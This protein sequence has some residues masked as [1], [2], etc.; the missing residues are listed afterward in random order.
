MLTALAATIREVSRM[1][2]SPASDS[3][4]GELF[5][6]SDPFHTGID[7]GAPAPVADDRWNSGVTRPLGIDSP[8]SGASIAAMTEPTALELSGESDPSGRYLFGKEIGRGGV[9]VVHEGR[10]TQLEREIA[11]KVLLPEHAGKAEVERRFLE[12]ARIAGRLQHPGIIAIHSLGTT[13]D[14]RPYFAMRLVR[15]ETL[16][17]ILKRRTDP[18]ADLPHLLNNF[19]QVCQ[20]VAYA[21]SEG[22][23]H[24]DLKPA[25]IMVGPF[26]IVKVM[27]WGLAKVLGEADSAAAIPGDFDPTLAGTQMGTVFGTPGYLPPEQARGEIDRIDKRAD[28]FGLG[29]ILC[30]ILTGHPAHTGAD[31]REVYRKAARGDMAEALARLGECRA[32]LDVVAL[33]TWCLAAERDDRP[34]NAGHVV[35]VLTAH[36]HSDMRRAQ[37]DLELFFDLSREMFC[38]AGTDGYFHRVNANFP[39]VLGHSATA[40]TSHPFIDFVHP[41]DRAETL[42]VLE[43]LAEGDRCVRFQNRYRHADGHHLWIEWNAESAPEL[44]AVYAVAR[45]VTERVAQ[46]EAHRR[47]EL[48]RFHLEAVAESEGLAVVG[49]TLDGVV[50]I[51]NAG[52]EQLFGYRAEE[53]VG[54]CITALLGDGRPDEATELLSRVKK[55]SAV[56][57]YETIHRRKDGT[58]LPVALTLAPVRDGAGEIIGVSKVARRR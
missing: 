51:W 32:P 21:H 34:E 2:A 57:R 54:R 12:E 38:I 22:V 25:N 9:G 14:G 31:G 42:R 28:V 37:Q 36:L 18:G 11:L 44:R 29:S 47:D 58:P 26:G 41:D 5:P 40:L 24:R 52:A 45:D 55:C 19:L 16:D 8:D 17:V 46:A 27:D 56:E 3:P 7:F 15:G 20:A 53:I 50:R 10:D 23:V 30:E 6:T 13:R 4:E 33:T 39:R 49:A 1:A 48:A 35:E 43:K